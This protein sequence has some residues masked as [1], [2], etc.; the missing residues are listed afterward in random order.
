MIDDMHGGPENRVPGI[1][2]LGV[3]YDQ[4]C[5]GSAFDSLIGSSLQKKYCR[6][7]GASVWYPTL[8]VLPPTC[9]GCS[10]G[11]ESVGTRVQYFP[12]PCT[13]NVAQSK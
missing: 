12:R 3:F 2:E 8:G 10:P 1:A 4:C 5:K 9:C 6:S 13:I 7:P 11:H